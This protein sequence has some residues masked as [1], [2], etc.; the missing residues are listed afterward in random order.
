[1]EKWENEKEKEVSKSQ[2]K[3]KPSQ[4]SVKGKSKTNIAHFLRCEKPFASEEEIERDY[5]LSKSS[6]KSSYFHVASSQTQV[7]VKKN[8]ITNHFWLKNFTWS[9]RQNEHGFAL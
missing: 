5:N 6:N 1:M 4:L 2:R 3:N 8:K 9:S 7:A